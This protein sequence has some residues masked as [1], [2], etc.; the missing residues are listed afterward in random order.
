M[1]MWSYRHSEHS[2]EQQAAN[3][4]DQFVG[5]HGFLQVKNTLPGMN[6]A[7]PKRG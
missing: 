7:G 4:H 2:T 5:E 1:Q 3:E 6:T